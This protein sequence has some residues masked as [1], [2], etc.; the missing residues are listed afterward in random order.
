MPT[1]AKKYKL[2]F[3]QVLG[4][5]IWS[6]AMVKNGLTYAY[7][8][9]FWGPH[10]H[11]A[12]WHLSLI[13]SLA[14]GSWQLPMYAGAPLHNY[15]FGFDF[16][17]AGLTKLTTIPANIWYFQIL[18]PVFALTIGFLVYKLTRSLWSVFFVYFG[19]GFGWIVT[20]LRGQGLGGESL[21]W[22]QQAISTLINPPFALSLILLLLG[23]L[24]LQSKKYFPAAL[25]FG[26][27]GFVKIY[28]GILGLAGLLALAVFGKNKK[29]FLTFAAAAVLS[30]ILFLPF[31]SL[32]VRSLIF[33]PFWF[34]RTLM[35]SA[36]RLNWP[37][38]YQA[39][40]NYQLAG[41]FIKLIPAYILATAIFILGNL[42]LRI[43]GVVN[44]KSPFYWT[45]IILG[46]V[47]PLL[48]V[49]SGTTWNTIQFFYYAQFFLALFAGMFL[50]NKSIIFKSLFV[51]LML[52]A[53]FATL[54]HYLPS[55]PPSAIPPAEIQALRFLHNQPPGIVLT[56]VFDK[57]DFDKFTEPRPLF[58]YES[59]AYVSAYSAHPVFLEDEVNLN[60]L[61]INWQPRHDQTVQFFNTT[62]TSLAREFVFA[63]H[64]TYLYLPQ[65]DLNCPRLNPD[66]LSMSVIFSDSQT[67]IWQVL[68]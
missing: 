7:G 14:K 50:E 4:S 13:N 35:A 45:V 40:I 5:A 63:N 33:Q 62:D 46:I 11:D 10:G 24:C 47:F 36:D 68:K 3:L 22:S 17:V 31:N 8:V 49:Q 18:P 2:I 23:L 67:A 37:R 55:R 21:F 26:L 25:V 27:A 64:I 66:Q 43:I 38:F 48:F 29:I 12:I 57:N 58:A 41:N 60:L 59:T 52:P 6:A 53:V 42:G 34:V 65:A 32:S 54:R 28:A 20:L 19:T 16:L 44:L 15:H 39:L 1:F 61:N 51:I 9:G 30:L 56:P